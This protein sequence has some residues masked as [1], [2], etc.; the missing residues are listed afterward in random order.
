MFKYL[1]KIEKYKAIGILE[2][3]WNACYESGDDYVGSAISIAVTVEWENDPKD[4]LN[5]LI[6]CGDGSTGF[7]EKDEIRDGYV[8]HDLF[9]HA[10]TYVQS[11]MTREADRVKKG[12]SISAMRKEAGRLGGIA[13]QAKKKQETF[14]QQDTKR[15]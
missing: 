12:Q 5:A 10:P 3:L 15:F 8:V 9:D 14:T 2:C 7:I 6:D 13:A 11:R 1:L 4:L